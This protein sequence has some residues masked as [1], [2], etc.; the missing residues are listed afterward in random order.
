MPQVYICRS[1]VSTIPKLSPIST[2]IALYS[3]FLTLCGVLNLPNVPVPHRYS[4]PDSFEIEALK[5]PAAIYFIGMWLI[6]STN[7]GVI[8]ELCS[9]V[10]PI[11]PSK[12]DPQPKTRPVTVK[13]S[14]WF[15]PQA[16]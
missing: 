12:F 5:L 1:S 2:Y 10:V 6:S 9:V 3:I 7:I 4:E 8:E 13:I 14:V 16:T 15:L 11:Y